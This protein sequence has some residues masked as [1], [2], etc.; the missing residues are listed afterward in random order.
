M[1]KLVTNRPSSTQIARSEMM[2][3]V[4]KYGFNW[5]RNIQKCVRKDRSGFQNDMGS[6]KQKQKNIRIQNDWKP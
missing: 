1:T 5:V 3:V 6:K 4:T 2:K